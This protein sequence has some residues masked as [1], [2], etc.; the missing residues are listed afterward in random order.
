MALSLTLRGCSESLFNT[1]TI[2]AKARKRDEEKNRKIPL[3]LATKS[4]K[5][6]CT[7]HS[8]MR[9]KLKH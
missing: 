3:G 4:R 7:T 1:N 5:E 6:K 2:R 8:G 9:R